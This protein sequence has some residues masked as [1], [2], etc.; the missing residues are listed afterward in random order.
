MTAPQPA[1]SVV[2]PVFNEEA[3]LPLLAVRLRGVLDGLGEAYEVVAVDDGSTDA[4]PAALAAL[5]VGWPELRVLRLRRNSGHQAALHAGLLRARG[6][7]VVSIDADLQDPPEVIVELLRRARADGVDVVYAV[8]ADRSRDTRFKRW[9]AGGYYRLVR[10]LVG[11]QVPAQAGDF[12]LLSRAA[13]TALRELPERGPVLRLVVPW[14]GFPSAEVTYERQERAAGRTKYPLSR[15]AGLA[16]ESVTSF[17]AAPLRVATWLGLVGVAVCGVL[18]VAAVLAWFA[19]ATVSGWPSLYV[20]IL[21]LG[22]VQLL[23]LGLLGEYVAR[24]YTAVQG[25][26][27]YLVA[28]DSAATGPAH[29]DPAELA[30]SLR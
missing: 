4:T 17:S 2:V 14:L 23:C 16:A 15:M 25:R 12:R 6:A 9:S 10:R 7:Y 8:R 5:R 30:D 19:G 26:P 11:E 24:I 20:A 21:F 13:V 28:G 29:P 1:L 27:A 22:A 3:V 18:V